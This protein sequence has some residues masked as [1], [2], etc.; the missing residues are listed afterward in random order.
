MISSVV[1]SNEMLKVIGTN[2]FVTNSRFFGIGIGY[3]TAEYVLLAPK[4]RLP[5][6]AGME[7]RFLSGRDLVLGGGI[8]Y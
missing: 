8:T 6:M 4:L 5:L 1:C 7:G 3:F 2:L